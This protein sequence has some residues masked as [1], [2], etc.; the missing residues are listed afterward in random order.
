MQQLS[1]K[2]GIELS[3]DSS[4]VT[5]PEGYH[6]T[7]SEHRITIPGHNVAGVINGVQSLRQLWQQQGKTLRVPCVTIND[8]PRF[9]Y[10]GMHLEVSRHMFPV[11]FIK[12]YI[13]LLALYK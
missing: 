3:V 6:L 13:D 11:S 10:R 7:A 2:D 8:Y 5:Q 9:G 12:K 1:D 4:T